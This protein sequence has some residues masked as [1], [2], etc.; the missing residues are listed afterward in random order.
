MLC[1]IIV[2]CAFPHFTLRQNNWMPI[3]SC[4]CAQIVLDMNRLCCQHIC[5]FPE[6]Q[7]RLICNCKHE[8]LKLTTEP[9]HALY[10]SCARTNALSPFLEVSQMTQQH[11]VVL[12]LLWPYWTKR[13]LAHPFDSVHYCDTTAKSTLIQK[14]SFTFARQNSYPAMCGVVTKYYWSLNN[15]MSVVAPRAQFWKTLKCIASQSCK[16]INL[17]LTGATKNR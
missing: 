9:A 3:K 11:P 13:F 17:Q 1:M 5:T 15:N 8:Q 10:Y 4:R 12:S 2:A 16:M 6:S 7:K 14:N